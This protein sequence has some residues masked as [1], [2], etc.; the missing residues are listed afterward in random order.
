MMCRLWARLSVVIAERY[1]QG[2]NARRSISDCRPRCL[3]GKSVIKSLRA[4]VCGIFKHQWIILRNKAVV[5]GVSLCKGPLWTTFFTQTKL[6]KERGTMPKD[7]QICYAWQ[8]AGSSALPRFAR[9]HAGTGGVPCLDSSACDCGQSQR[10]GKS[11]LQGIM[12][13]PHVWPWDFVLSEAAQ[14]NLD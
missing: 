1:S 7:R 3:R 14:G 5:V 12:L 10:Q 8:R 6:K 11:W 13:L 9:Q 4:P 2:V